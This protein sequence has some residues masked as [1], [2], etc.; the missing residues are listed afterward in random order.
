MSFR[1]ELRRVLPPDASPTLAEYQLVAEFQQEVS[2]RQ[3]HERYC[4]WYSEVAER[5]RE[6]L[7][8]LRGDI[9]LFGWF[10]RR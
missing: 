8:K 10:S 5:N 3:E 1:E 9:N 4:Q 6:E 2:W 7:L